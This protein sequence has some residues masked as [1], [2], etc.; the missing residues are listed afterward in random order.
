VSANGCAH[1]RV[2][3]QLDLFAKAVE[4]HC[5]V[6]GCNEKKA[7]ALRALGDGTENPSDEY[8]MRLAATLAK[9]AW[10]RKGRR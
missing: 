7:F 6:P 4:V 1:D 5:L 9:E 3:T 10:L 2:G 8:R